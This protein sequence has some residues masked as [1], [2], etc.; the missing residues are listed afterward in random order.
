MEYVMRTAVRVMMLISLVILSADAKL[1]ADADKEDAF[2]DKYDLDRN[3]KVTRQEMPGFMR[4][5]F[6]LYDYNGDGFVTKVELR[7]STIEGRKRVDKGFNQANR[8]SNGNKLSFNALD[9]DKDGFISQYEM[10]QNMISNLPLYDINGDKRLSH[11][12]FIQMRKGKVHSRSSYDN[13]NKHRNFSF[14]H[15]DRNRDGLIVKGEMSNK[16]KRIY[17][18]YDKNSDGMLNREEYNNLLAGR[19]IQPKKKKQYVRR[20]TP[21]SFYYLDL[22]RDGFITKDEVTSDF[23]VRFYAYDINGDNKISHSEF[24]IT[25]RKTNQQNRNGYGN[26][27][28]GGGNLNQ[29]YGERFEQKDGYDKILGPSNTSDLY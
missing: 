7:R 28:Q 24:R 16:L 21:G 10:T 15:F 26:D 22:N 19:V 27:S 17:R 12:E 6:H 8:V 4:S 5:R 3:N 1:L 2:F 13:N 11:S 9:R 18:S 20:G 29:D 25:K 23:K 14:N